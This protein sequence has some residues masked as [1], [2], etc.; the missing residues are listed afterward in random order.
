[1]QRW[2]FF[3]FCLVWKGM[4]VDWIFWCLCVYM[5]LWVRQKLSRKKFKVMVFICICCIYFCIR[6]FRYTALAQ[7]WFKI[8]E[9]GILPHIDNFPF[10]SI[11][12]TLY[13]TD[14]LIF[15]AEIVS[16]PLSQAKSAIGK[17]IPVVNYN[18]V[19]KLRMWRYMRP[20][21]TKQ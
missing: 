13:E 17:F 4:H 9:W 7:F 16:I 6:S 1:M 18:S 8:W 2:N 5:H 12:A 21:S 3:Y 20:C 11:C 10:S 14:G 19:V 15:C